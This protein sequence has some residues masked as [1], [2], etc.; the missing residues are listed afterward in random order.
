M[1][2]DKVIIAALIVLTAIIPAEIFTQIM[3]YFNF[4]TISIIEAMSMMWYPKG[5]LILGLVAGFG[6]GSW[7]GI[8]TYYSANFWGTDYFPLKA[9]L[10]AMT[11]QSLIFTIYGVLGG[12]KNLT[13][14]VGGNLVHTAAAVMGGL[15]TGFLMRKYLR[16]Q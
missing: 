11:V 10:I 9:M 3:K 16:D 7:I 13:Q 2:Q 5:S 6:I 12:N 15:L 8:L 1:K 4:T 14:N